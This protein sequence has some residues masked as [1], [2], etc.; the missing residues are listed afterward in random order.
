ME[1]VQQAITVKLDDGREITLE[2]HS[3]RVFGC[4]WANG[5]VAEVLFYDEPQPGHDVSDRIHL[6]I[7]PAGGERRGWL[8]NI[9]EAV[10]VISGLTIGMRKAIETGVPMVAEPVRASD[11]G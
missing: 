5:A 6:L 3:Q 2:A 1:D 10:E 4:I 8:M 11:T 7:T 9:E